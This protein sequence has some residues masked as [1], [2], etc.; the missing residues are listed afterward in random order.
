MSEQA[1][2]LAALD[3]LHM[4]KTSASCPSCAALQERLEAA[5]QREPLG[6]DGTIS[7]YPAPALTAR[8][9]QL[10]AQ[11]Q[12]I[13]REMG[14]VGAVIGRKA[15]LTTDEMAQVQMVRQWQQPLW[16]ASLLLTEQAQ[17]IAKLTETV[18]Q[19]EQEAAT[20]MQMDFGEGHSA[21]MQIVALEAQVATLTQEQATYKAEIE[22]MDDRRAA[23]EAH[24]ATLT[25]DRDKG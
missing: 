21:A 7:V 24:V 2:I 20:C 11:L 18:K 5:S 13:Y 10:Q 8:A 9:E 1:R 14:T 4:P 22:R 19:L 16:D 12:R 3:R 6:T 17:Q 23:A 25:Q 15:A